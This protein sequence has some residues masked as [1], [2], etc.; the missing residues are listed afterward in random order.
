MKPSHY[1][2][3]FY[4]PLDKLEAVK[5]AVFDTGAGSQGNYRNCCWQT[6]GQGQ[7]MP[8]EGAKPA[9]G[10]QHKLEQLQEYKVEILCEA[11]VIK[12]AVAA[13]KQAHPYEEPAFDVLAL[14]DTHEW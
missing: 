3:C 2:L 5:Q 8:V 6:V 12:Q 4:V 14:I 9:I 13:L 1:K 10:A 7:F 11:A